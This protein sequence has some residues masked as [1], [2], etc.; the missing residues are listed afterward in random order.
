MCVV[1][2]G[3]KTFKAEHL[4]RV[5]SQTEMEEKAGARSTELRARARQLADGMASGASESSKASA[6]GVDPK[7]IRDAAVHAQGKRWTDAQQD[8]VGEAVANGR[9]V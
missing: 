7:V 9:I 1:Q 5:A 6:G 8:K 3:G 2:H 4:P